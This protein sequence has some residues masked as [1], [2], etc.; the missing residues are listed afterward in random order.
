[1]QTVLKF[2]EVSQKM[3]R[4]YPVLKSTSDFDM[5]RKL[6]T[7]ETLEQ[8][9]ADFNAILLELQ[10]AFHASDSILIGDLLEYEISPRIENLTTLINP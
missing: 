7:G 10:K 4:L 5:Q 2:I 9:Y 3:I 6:N 8:F 1:M